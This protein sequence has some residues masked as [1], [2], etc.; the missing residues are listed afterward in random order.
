MPRKPP[1]PLVF[2]APVTFDERIRQ[3][4]RS[5]VAKQLYH[6][7]RSKEEIDIITMTEAEFEEFCERVL[8]E[9]DDGE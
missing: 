9:E 1:E 4:V 5:T 2:P 3:L 7:L 8:A 6:V